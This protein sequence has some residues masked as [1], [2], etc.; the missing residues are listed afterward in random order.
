MTTEI[1]KTLKKSLIKAKEVPTEM[2][3]ERLSK[4]RT[5]LLARPMRFSQVHQDVMEE[6]KINNCLMCSKPFRALSNI[7]KVCSSCKQ[8]ERW[9]GY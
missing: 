6:I 9:R 4:T 8:T 1:K 5:K 2:K 7:N 3:S